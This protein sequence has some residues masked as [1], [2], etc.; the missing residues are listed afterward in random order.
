M[1][2]KVT[3]A[4]KPNILGSLVGKSVGGIDQ[5]GYSTGQK[6]AQMTLSPR[7][8]AFDGQQ[9]QVGLDNTAHLKGKLNNLYENIRALQEQLSTHKKEM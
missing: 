3:P 6:F 4:F 1:R 2:Q 9:S 7:S 5:I 8:N